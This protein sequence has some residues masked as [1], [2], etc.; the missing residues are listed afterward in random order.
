MW[1][2]PEKDSVIAMWKAGLADAVFSAQDYFD[3]EKFEIFLKKEDM[4]L[5]EA[6]FAIKVLVWRSTNWQNYSIIDLNISFFGGQFKQF[7]TA[8]E[9]IK[10]QDASVL[11]CDYQTFLNSAD[12]VFAG[13]SVLL[14]QVQEFERALS[15]NVARKASWG[16]ANYALKSIYNPETEQGDLG[17]ESQVVDL[18]ARTDLFFG[19]VRLAFEPMLSGQQFVTEQKFINHD[20]EYNRIFHAAEHL[21]IRLKVLAEQSGS[22]LLNIFIENL[23]HFFASKTEEDVRWIEMRE[24]YCAFITQPLFVDN[25]AK[26]VYQSFSGE[27]VFLQSKSSSAVENYGVERVGAQEF[28]RVEYMKDNK[29]PLIPVQASTQPPENLA[30]FELIRTN[31]LPIV[32]A[33][34]TLEQIKEFYRAFHTELNAL[35]VIYAQGY[36]GGSN[37]IVRNFG[38]RQQSMLIVTHEFLAAVPKGALKP[39]TVILSGLSKLDSAHPYA[40]ALEKHYDSDLIEDFATLRAVQ[41]FEQMVSR[42]YHPGLQKLYFQS[43]EDLLAISKSFLEAT[44]YYSME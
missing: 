2:L 31:S 5:E 23:E 14:E 30:L 3:N 20:Y 12:D 11:V 41:V 4:S 8:D 15:R 16:F 35:G 37:K 39:V 19:I 7:I 33:L 32:I 34:P 44:G 42:S 10:P 6:R 43:D 27:I 40:Q 26:E 29:Q 36:S 25:L 13:R 22:E 17:Y 1:V 38:L 28:M 21:T 24:G 9:I 18:L